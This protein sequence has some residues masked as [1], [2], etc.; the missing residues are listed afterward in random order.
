MFSE[1]F[2]IFDGFQTHTSAFLIFKIK[3]FEETT[4]AGQSLWP[5]LPS[6]FLSETGALPRPRG[7]EQPYLWGQRDPKENPKQQAL[8]S[9]P[10]LTTPASYALPSPAPPQPC[11]L[12]HRKKHSALVVSLGLPFVRSLPCHVKLTRNKCVCFSPVN[13]FSLV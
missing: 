9:L 8:V 6:P 2:F 1:A 3:W 13:L 12:N 11:A 5:L 7:K 4:E 10:Q